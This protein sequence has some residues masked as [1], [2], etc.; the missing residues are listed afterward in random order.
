MANLKKS[1]FLAPTWDIPPTAVCLG[2]LITDFT[3][4][5]YPINPIEG[6]LMAGP[7]EITVP[8]IETEIFTD[9]SSNFSMEIS[10]DSSTRLGIWGQ[11]LRIIGISTEAK[12][13]LSKGT[14]NKYAFDEMVT[15]WFSPS[16]TYV[17]LLVNTKNVRD[18]LELAGTKKPLYVITGVKSVSGAT[19]STSRSAGHTYN[20]KFGVDGAAAGAP[21]TVGPEFER[22]SNEGLSITHYKDKPMVF[23]YQLMKVVL[24]ESKPRAS[25][26]VKGA[27]FETEGMEKQ[28]TFEAIISQTLTPD[29]LGPSGTRKK[30]K[31]NGTVEYG[32]VECFEEG[33][34]GD[35]RVVAPVKP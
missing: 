26:Y 4:P 22:S 13:V 20:A 5:R 14:A 15:Q 34:C 23:A 8:G 17:S 1:W 24:N 16:A 31:R 7:Q 29:E 28:L 35:L 10:G 25:V 33:S 21:M 11:F 30:S 19:L 32:T 9:T 2:H 27:M 12:L 6:G 3:D 18:F